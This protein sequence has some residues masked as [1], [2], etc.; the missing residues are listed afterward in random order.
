M[1]ILALALFEAGALAA[2]PPGALPPAPDVT[3]S[4]KPLRAP[5]PDEIA[6][7]EM[8]FSPVDDG[9]SGH[10][11]VTLTPQNRSLTAQ[12]ARQAAEDAFLEA[13][14]EPGLGAVLTRIQVVVYLEPRPG[15]QADHKAFVYSTSNGVSW[16][17]SG[18]ETFIF[19]D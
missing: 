2:T 19:V 10:I 12:E 18:A 14:N 3:S 5:I 7:L 1:A 11:R 13:L 9:L 16:R 6:E 4:I 15:P 8:R 17:L